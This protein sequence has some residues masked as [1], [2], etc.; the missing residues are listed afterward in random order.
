MPKNQ[1]TDE[2]KQRFLSI[3]RDGIVKVHK[4]ELEARDAKIKEYAEALSISQ[5]TL[6]R[7]MDVKNA[8]REQIDIKSDSP[9]EGE[10]TAV[11][12]AS[13]WHSEET[14]LP[15]TVF[16]M[17]EFNPSVADARIKQFFKSIVRLTE[18]ERNGTKINKL[19]LGLIGDFISGYIHEE[20]QESNA[21][22]PTKAII[23]V[24]E[25]LSAG[26]N[27]LKK[28][29]RFDV[30]DIVCCDGNHG[31]TTRKPRSSTRT[32]NSNEWLLYQVLR[33]EHPDV[34][35]HIADGYF[36]FQKIYD[37]EVRWHHGDDI[38]YQGGVGGPTISINKA[39]AQWNKARPAYIDLFGHLHTYL[40]A[41]NFC[42][43]GSLIGYNAYAI[44]IK[45]PYEP[46][47]QTYFLM[48]SKRGRTV[49]TPILFG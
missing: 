6:T 16:G 47:Q 5:A 4:K 27:F 32:D 2:Q 21:M 38:L 8:P 42:L 45:A 48:D 24:L 40:Q 25:R 13:D 23:W 12:I 9:T 20:L 39:I 18:I 29:G 11:V 44:T 10:A 3:E 1:K 30:I 28:E 49:T 22:S 43:N 19:S 34:N 15:E 26:I 36:V 46:P 33:R 41:P 31:R 37:R 7:L 17:N 35:W 14:V